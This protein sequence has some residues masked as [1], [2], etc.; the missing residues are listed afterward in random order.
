AELQPVGIA[1]DF[2]EKRGRDVVAEG[3]ADLAL[4]GIGDDELEEDERGVDDGEADERE[5]RIDHE[6]PGPEG[7][8]GEG[9]DAGE[10]DRAAQEARE[11]AEAED[12]EDQKRA[13]HEE[14]D[15]FEARDPI[16]AG[17]ID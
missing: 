7:V 5:A 6:A 3:A 1:L 13:E 11:R 17:E 2:S 15:D 16:G 14:T 4:V 12:D 8:P 10:R 9:G